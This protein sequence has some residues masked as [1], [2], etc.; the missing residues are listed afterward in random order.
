[1]KTQMTTNSTKDESTEPLLCADFFKAYGFS[2][3]IRFW[4]EKQEQFSIYYKIE[5]YDCD[6][7]VKPITQV[8]PNDWNA[9]GEGV[10]EMPPKIQVDNFSDIETLEDHHI[11][12]F[13]IFVNSFKNHI[14]TFSYQFEML[15][16]MSICGCPL[17]CMSWK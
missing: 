7:L 9:Y 10:H 16:F 8:V 11:G 1:M 6:I 2:K 15:E 5:G 4:D 14:A 13:Q 12:S 3:P 17:T